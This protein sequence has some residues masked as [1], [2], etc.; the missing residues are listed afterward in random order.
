MGKFQ[1][2]QTQHSQHDGFDMVGLD[3]KEIH[4]TVNGTVVHAG[5]ENPNNHSQGF[6]QYV[7]IKATDGNYYYFGHMSVVKASYG[8][9]VKITDVIGIEGNTGY[10]FG[11]HCH[12]CCRPNFTVGNALNI[13]SISG[14]PNALGI[15]DDGYRSGTTA[16]SDAKADIK[17]LQT[18]LNNAGAGLVVDGIVG[19]KTLAAVKKYSIELNDR[20][21]LIKWVQERLTQLGFNAGY[22]DGFAE[23]PTM[24]AI[25]SWQKANGL[26]VGNL[27]G[28]DW[29]VL[30]R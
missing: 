30:L 18:I 26:G 14:I 3:S 21:N 9:A 24:D 13:S 22:A 23:K 28:S 6:G 12:Y 15:Y 4:S 2:T 8:Q 11:S 19:E 17:G 16:S 10:S 29:D 25:Y 27:Y 7:C 20:G 1:I 5:W